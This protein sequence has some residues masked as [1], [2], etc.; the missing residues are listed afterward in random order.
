LEDFLAREGAFGESNV[1]WTVSRNSDGQLGF[2]GQVNTGSQHITF[3][4][5]TV[6]DIN[7][8][9]RGERVIPDP[10]TTP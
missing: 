7:N 3:N 2:T 9:K 10:T 8:A 6:S 5:A 1:E 4:K